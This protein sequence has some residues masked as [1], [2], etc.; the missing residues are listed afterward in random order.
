MARKKGS[1][2]IDPRSAVGR[3]S[4]KSVAENFLAV[5]NLP[6]LQYVFDRRKHP[7]ERVSWVL[8][9][10]AAIRG[11]L[12]LGQ[13][14]YARYA[15]NPT[16]IQLDKNYRD[17]IGIM[18]G[19]TFCFHDRVDWGKAR[20]YLARKHPQTLESL[21]GGSFPV[22]DSAGSRYL[23]DF[24]QTLVDAT[25]T[26]FG[27]LS[28]FLD[29]T[30]HLPADA[31][32]ILELISSVHPHH[33]I[34]INSIQPATTV[35]AGEEVPPVHQIVTERGI[36][37]SLNAPLSYLQRTNATER[38][39][40]SKKDFSN[41]QPISCEFNRHH[42][43]MKLDMYRSTVSY[44]IH[45]P[46]EVASIDQLFTNVEESDELVAVYSVLEMVA[47]ERLKDLTV[48]QR[49][50]FFYD[51]TYEQLPFYSHNLCVMSCRAKRA[52]ALC[53]CRPHFYPFAEG[54]QCTVKGLHCLQHRHPE[55][56]SDV[57]CKCL[58]SCTDVSFYVSSLSKTQWTSEGGIP[59][60]H[61][62]SLRWEIL[63]PRTRLRRVLIFSYEDLLVS[64]GGA[65]ALFIGK[66][67][68]Y[69]SKIVEF[70]TIELA[71]WIRLKL[72]AL[73]ERKR[74]SFRLKRY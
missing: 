5:L 69:V 6:G 64:F 74:F 71:G 34:A 13:Y 62:A 11:V 49:N 22:N 44:T 70:L 73:Q 33:D 18:P 58:K 21:P 57:G 9:I 27:N 47:N 72:H 52:L 2:P 39:L 68:F 20:A 14:Q 1:K 59:F 55:W 36:C 53:R 15:A 54:P 45:S 3:D 24:V 25:A 32:D 41:K 12:L 8:V 48:K 30:R 43:Y 50:C 35:G 37:Y 16:A 40:P 31:V 4:T 38:L 29:D 28:R 66:N 60:T 65:V 7:L 61:K 19:L 56:N 17:W 63:Q 67:G 10:L 26:D 46:Y 51:E 42:C 23:T